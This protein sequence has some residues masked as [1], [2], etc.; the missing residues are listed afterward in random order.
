MIITR[1]LQA[2]LLHVQQEL[3]SEFREATSSLR[4][5]VA[6]TAEEKPSAKALSCAATT[7]DMVSSSLADIGPT[8]EDSGEERYKNCDSP[9]RPS[10]APGAPISSSSP[11]ITEEAS[12][13]T[14][15]S[16]SVRS[17]IRTRARQGGLSQSASSESKISLTTTRA[18]P[19]HSTLPSSR[20]LKQVSQLSVLSGKKTEGSAARSLGGNTAAARAND[21]VAV[22][23]W[24]GVQFHT[25]AGGG[26][27]GSISGVGG[28]G[29]GDGES[30]GVN[31]G[32]GER[33]F[34]GSLF[35]ANGQKSEVSWPLKTFSPRSFPNPQKGVQA[36]ALEHQSE[37]GLDSRMASAMHTSSTA[38]AAHLFTRA[39]SF[40]VKKHLPLLPTPPP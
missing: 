11:V 2:Q 26:N 12:N 32:P 24:G 33:D 16:R 14:N 22:S 38:A 7:G 31:Y 5:A 6:A 40:D 3:V 18:Q 23:V 1:T 35:S 21:L 15:A 34:D 39:S 28:G 27:S 19:G 29:G 30:D 8:T 36:R 25:I 37:I 4:T 13:I 20:N 17:K 10:S 9:L